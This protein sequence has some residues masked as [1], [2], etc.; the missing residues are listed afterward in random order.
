MGKQRR[1][2]VAGHGGALAGRTQPDSETRERDVGERAA[3]VTAELGHQH[4]HRGLGGRGTEKS[5]RSKDGHVG[6]GGPRVTGD[7]ALVTR[8]TSSIAWGGER[9]GG[10][11]Q[12]QSEL[13]GRESAAE[14]QRRGERGGVAER[15]RHEEEGRR[16]E[17]GM[18]AERAGAEWGTG[19]GGRVFEAA[20]EGGEQQRRHR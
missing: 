6:G 4:E 15:G 18:R 2:L 17:G 20:R 14:T 7:I 8:D 11:R 19:S 12:R 10:S 5:A 16:R 3:R 9:E 13:D 1:R